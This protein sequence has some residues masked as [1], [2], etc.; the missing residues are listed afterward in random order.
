[1]NGAA[2]L[3]EAVVQRRPYWSERHVGRGAG[4]AGLQ[5]TARQFADLVGRLVTRGYFEKA[6]DKDCVDDPAVVDPAQL[7]ERALGVPGLWPLVPKR[8]AE[9]LDVFCD[10]VEVLHDLVARPRARWMHSYAGCG[11]HHSDFSLEAGRVLYR[12]Q[13]NILLEGSDLGLR[14][15]DEGEDVGRL[16]AAT[17]PA[18]SDLLRAMAQR[19]DT[20]GDR[21]RHAIV[22]YR[23]R[24]A[25]EHD[26]RSAV[27]VLSGVLEERRKLIKAE[28]LS[29]DE[30]DLFMVANKFG[31]RHQSEQQ[32]RDYS[33][34][35]LDW[36]FWWYL[37]TIELTDRL[38]TR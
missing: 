17:D 32:K 31:I 2:S 33:V 12:W 23:A 27:I 1:M 26:K 35:F 22:L 6:F 8:L 14:L 11:W 5:A 24:Q 36:I 38:G 10:V 16:V 18:R 15:A 3:R 25:T 7:L 34:E 28:L 37:A 29:K 30:D 4:P 13:V 21:V 9:D 19:D 20:I